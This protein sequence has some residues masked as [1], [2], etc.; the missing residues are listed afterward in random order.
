MTTIN[1]AIPVL[2]GKAK[3][4][5]DKGH[6]WSVIEH[7]LLIAL[8]QKDW[9]IDALSK[10]SSLPRRI[11]V[12]SVTRL[13]RAGWVELNQNS[14]TTFRANVFARIALDQQELPNILERK[15][16]PT[17]FIVDLITGSIFRNREWAVFTEQTIKERSIKEPFIIINTESEQAS[18]DVTGM[19]DILLDPDETFVSAE[20]KGVIRRYVV[21][22]IRDG[23]IYGLPTKR[24]L[25]ELRSHI[26]SLVKLHSPIE[27]S[28]NF[29]SIE[30]KTQFSDRNINEK[31]SPIREI[32]FNNRDIICGGSAH[33]DAFKHAIEKAKTKIIIHSTFIEEQNFLQFIP[34]FK[35]VVKR[36]VTIHIFWGQN[37]TTEETT[38]SRSAINALFENPELLELSSNITIH[39]HSTGSHSKF[40]IS[41]SGADGDFIAIVGSCNWFTS[42]FQSYETS[43]VLRDP[44][45]VKDVLSYASRL[46]CV[47][48][49]IWTELATEIA[50]IGRKLSSNN[51]VQ[52]TNAIASI[53]IGEQHSSY[54]IK[55]RDEAKERIFITS[56]RLGAT[57]YSSVLPSFQKASN[58]SN[59]KTEIYYG[60]ETDPVTSDD[61]DHITEVASKSGVTLEMVV[62][63]K[64]HAKI[65]SWDNDHILVSSLNWLSADPKGSDNLKE[66]GIY[67]QAKEAATVIINNFHKTIFEYSPDD[68]QNNVSTKEKK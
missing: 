13:M 55:S 30:I 58:H 48:D 37:D 38:S 20:P 33:Y 63:P 25:P 47:H 36:G 35:D 27:N 14:N 11:V 49:G 1:I 42:Q 43:V 8:A 46:C 53:V 59:V 40:V 51:K 2:K 41:D 52:K 24:D 34:V 22:T 29:E 68:N 54:I 3:F 21:A 5:V 60:R 39:P 31:S 18:V 32:N 61:I 10:H 9:T 45:I 15:N 66:L 16:R 26:T 57:L 44:Q 56:H 19:L 4:I 28:E 12:E 23:I 67:I 17:N 50:Q 65:L 7:L 6:S 62:N 64:L